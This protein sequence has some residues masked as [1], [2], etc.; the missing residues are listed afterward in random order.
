MKSYWEDSIHDLAPHTWEAHK[1][2]LNHCLELTN[3]VFEPGGILETQFGKPY[4]KGQHSMAMDV[5]RSFQEGRHLAAEAGTGTGKT[6][7]YGVPAAILG[8]LHPGIPSKNEDSDEITTNPLQTVISV[9]TLS[10]QDQLEEDFTLIAEVTKAATGSEPKTL[11][12]SGR[13]NYFCE[14]STR[15]MALEADEPT[16]KEAATRLLEE[17]RDPQKRRKNAIRPRCTTSQLVSCSCQHEAALYRKR[18]Q[19]CSTQR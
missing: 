5:A 16:I 12:L 18:T 11:R 19:L 2:A 8:I 15:R 4:R 1:E 13:E 6:L 17:Y 14:V 9:H 3:R 10:L 7:A